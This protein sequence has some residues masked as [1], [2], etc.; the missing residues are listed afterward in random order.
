MLLLSE[1]CL[2][3]RPPDVPLI[4]PHL[5]TGEPPL[6]PRHSSLITQLYILSLFKGRGHLLVCS[7]SSLVL[8]EQ[9]ALAVISF[10]IAVQTCCSC[11]TSRLLLFPRLVKNK[12]RVF[13]LEAVIRCF[14]SCGTAFVSRLCSPCSYRCL[15]FTRCPLVVPSA[16]ARSR[17]ACT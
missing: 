13:H 11:P 15:P 12:A 3:C 14:N 9:G 8:H 4:G 1:S 16:P 7:P 2:P 5:S 6:P 17:K 10:A